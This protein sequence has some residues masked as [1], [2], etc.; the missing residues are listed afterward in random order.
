MLAANNTAIMPVGWNA[1]GSWLGAVT[2]NR[3]LV[4]ALLAVSPIL[5]WRPRRDPRA[6]I[7]LV[8]IASG[9]IGAAAAYYGDAAEIAR[10]CYG[11]GQQIVLG[12]VL[13]ALAACD[14]ARDRAHDA[15]QIS[16]EAER[17]P[18]SAMA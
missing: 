13:A 7:A 16:V 17:T 4:L 9:A 10:H 18:P 5:L 11:A 6:G 3:W 8:M 2:T 12:L 14:R 1:H 15:A